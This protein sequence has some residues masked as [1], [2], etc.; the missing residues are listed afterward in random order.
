M[1]RKE[2]PPSLLRQSCKVILQRVSIHGIMQVEVTVTRPPHQGTSLYQGCFSL[3]SLAACS[4]T[5]KGRL[6]RY[7]TQIWIWEYVNI[8]NHLFPLCPDFQEQ[9]LIL[10]ES[11]SSIDL[12]RIW[13][14]SP[15]CGQTIISELIDSLSH[16]LISPVR[17]NSEC[18][19]S[20]SR[21]TRTLEVIWSLIF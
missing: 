3:R 7:Y 4:G 1:S 18:H 12:P 21:G 19:F 17:R 16:R 9:L 10:V 6:S 5:Y 8:R 20:L 14:Q 2:T 13:R 15:V 11:F